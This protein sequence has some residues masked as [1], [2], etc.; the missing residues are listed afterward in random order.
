M[1]CLVIA[2]WIVLLTVPLDGAARTSLIG[3]PEI[4]RADGGAQTFTGRVFEDLDGDSRFDEGEPGVAGVR[5]SN[6]L[7]WTRTDAEGRYSIA[8]RDDMNLTIVQ[9]AGWRVPVDDK[10][11]PQF[12]YVHKPGGSP[13]PLRFGG[14]PDTGPVPA[15]VNFPLIRRASAGSDFRCAILGDT[16]TYSNQEIHWLRDG[17]MTDL[18]G[19]GL[20]A[21]DCMLYVGDVVGDDLGL[22]DR[23]LE[24]GAAVGAP[25]WLVH[26]NHDFDFDAESDADSADSWRR[27]VG[28]EYYAFEHGQV[29]FVVLDNV[30]YPCG[31]DPADADHAFCG[32]PERPNYNGRISQ[33]QMTWLAGLLETV[34][35]ERKVVVATHVPLVSFVDSRSPKHQTDNTGELHALLDGRAALSLSGHTHTIE[36][37]AP[38]QV[39]EGWPDSAGVDSLPFRHII[40][41]A[42]SGAWFGGDFD[43]NGNPMTLQRMGAPS[44]VLLLDFDGTD[45]RERYRGS[46]IDPERRQW[47]ALSTPSFRDWFEAIMEWRE[48][49]RDTRHPMPP[50]S[51]ND[52]PDTGLLTAEDLGQGTWLTVNVWAGSSETR[53]EA[54]LI[55]PDGTAIELEPERTQSGTGEA[56]KI[57]AEWADPF[58]AQRQLSVGRWA[59]TS[60]IGEGRA[61]GF[62]Q[63]KGSRRGPDVPQPQ[64]AVADRN[65]HLWRARLPQ[66]LSPGVYVAE[67]TSTDRHGQSS[68]DRLLFEVRAERPPRYFRTDVWNGTGN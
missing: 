59:M 36:N 65:M 3:A 45:V 11:L 32:D 35:M 9:P 46:R 8:A 42:G 38:G 63:F 58:A 5:V 52:L 27:I 10:Q 16:Q 1:H 22:L 2:C 40:A 50:Y 39:F 7:Q 18:A 30:V 44:G 57:G 21:D 60:R 55:R 24:V 51:I 15:S 20:D 41:G 56:P 17:P 61:Q 49:D 26:G 64:G 6:G 13:D 47:L 68:T 31:P 4:I 12:F 28:P 14:L 43:I 33:T 62:E 23:L 53:V 54:R 48:Q 37:H 29:L 67:V 34:P 66:D 25:Q 19:A